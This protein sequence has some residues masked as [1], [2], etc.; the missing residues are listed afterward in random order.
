[1]SSYRVN[2]SSSRTICRFFANGHCR[3]G[4]NCHYLHT[5]EGN[6][7]RNRNSDGDEQNSYNTGGSSSSTLHKSN[8]NSN[9]RR[10]NN[11][12]NRVP[13]ESLLVCKYFL[14]DRCMFGD[15]CWYK[16]EKSNNTKGID[17]VDSNEN[18]LKSQKDK[19]KAKE[20]VVEDEYT[21]AICYDTPKT[22]GLLIHCDHIFCRDCIQVWRKTSNVSSPFQDVDTTKTCPV[23][24]KNSPYVVPSSRF[25][26]AGP[27]KEQIISTYKEKIS[28]IPC[29]Y[30]EGS[31]KCPFAD[32]CFY[33]HANPDGSRYWASNS[34]GWS[35]GIETNNVIEHDEDCPP[36]WRN[37]Y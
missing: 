35:W 15:S 10:S 20:V 25:A 24:R 6:S 28:Q 11:S 36:D 31:G 33:Q 16:H 7:P 30:F 14:E 27:Q 4:P 3:N 22:F 2:A 23:C 29:K 37:I 9:Y 32:E 5:R 34:N 12:N 26:K 21:C 18:D 13:P 19:Q 1:M 8:S 17:T